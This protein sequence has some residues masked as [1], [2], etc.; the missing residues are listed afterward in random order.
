MRLAAYLASLPEVSD[1]LEEALRTMHAR[2]VATWEAIVGPVELTAARWPVALDRLAA[3]PDAARASIRTLDD[4]LLTL[5]LPVTEP[6]P[7]DDVSHER[8]GLLPIDL[9]ED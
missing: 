1:G 8:P 9:A 7:L 2:N 6:A 4:L 5:K 3:L